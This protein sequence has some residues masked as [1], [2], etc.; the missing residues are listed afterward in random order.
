VAVRFHDEFV[1]VR[2]RDR[3]S[4]LTFFTSSFSLRGLHKGSVAI[5]RGGSSEP[6]WRNA[7][8]IV[9]EGPVYRTKKNRRTEPNQTSVRSFFQLRLPT[10][11][12]GPVAGCLVLKI[13]E[14][15]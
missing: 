14:N 10:F 5:V 6:S 4:V 12:V 13:F 15:R 7:R 9:F 8:C 2:F 3:V 1:I 11:G